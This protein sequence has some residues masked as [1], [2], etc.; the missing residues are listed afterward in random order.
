MEVIVLAI[1]TYMSGV[2]E[3]WI[4]SVHP[5]EQ[6]CEAALADVNVAPGSLAVCAWVT[7]GVAA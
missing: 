7:P 1:I 5:T 3:V 2:P 4:L 6:H